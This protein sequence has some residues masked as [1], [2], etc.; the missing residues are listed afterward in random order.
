MI[1]PKKH[2]KYTVTDHKEKDIYKVPKNKF[3]IMTLRKLSNIQESTDKQ[4]NKIRKTI[5]NLKKN[6]TNK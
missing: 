4:F 1:S 2:S 6:S 3:K 5:H